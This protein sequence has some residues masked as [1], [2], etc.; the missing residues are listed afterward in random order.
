MT[1]RVEAC[2]NLWIIG[3][4]SSYKYD[5]CYVGS[6]TL[7]RIVPATFYGATEQRFTPVHPRSFLNQLNS[8]KLFTSS[9]GTIHGFFTISG[10]TFLVVASELK[11]VS[12][13]AIAGQDPESALS[14]KYFPYI[15]SVPSRS[16]NRP[17]TAMLFTCHESIWKAMKSACAL[18]VRLHAIE[19]ERILSYGRC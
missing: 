15:K 19:S 7:C 18:A 12:H 3:D 11:Q 13:S 2:W 4:R 6:L 10:V 1:D 9:L 5:Y 14:Q 16:R 8:W 17:K